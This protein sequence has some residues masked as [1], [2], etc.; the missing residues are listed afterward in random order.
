MN[1]QHRGAG[2]CGQECGGHAG[3]LALR[4]GPAGDQAQGAF[5]R[6]ADQQWESQRLELVLAVQQLQVVCRRLGKANTGIQHD[7]LR[8]HASGLHGLHPVGQPLQYLL[9]HITGVVGVL[10]HGAGLATHVHQAHPRLPMP[11]Q[12]FQS[13]GSLQGLNIVDDVGAH[14]QGS[15]HDLG[16]TGIHRHRQPPAHHFGEH[17]RQSRPFLFG[18]HRRC[19]RSR[20]FATQVQ[21]VGA[22]L[23][24][25]LRVGQRCLGC[26]VLTTVGKGVRCEVDDPHHHRAVQ[27]QLETPGGPT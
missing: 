22:L 17:R 27:R 21:D 23:H 16:S 2:L 9:H 20:A 10:L 1:P 24:Q 25:A 8:L 14:V 12:Q 7:A 5:A 4:R 13:A 11:R 6:P 3:C 26:I 15:G 19:T 18:R